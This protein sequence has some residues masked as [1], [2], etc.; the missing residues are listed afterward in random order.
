MSFNLVIKLPLT[1][2]TIPLREY[3]GTLSQ[4]RDQTGIEP[5]ASSTYPRGNQ[6]S[7]YPNLPPP[8]YAESVFGRFNVKAEN[9]KY[10][11]GDFE[12]VP[13]YAMYN[14]NCRTPKNNSNNLDDMAFP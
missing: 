12:F 6:F 7:A 3:F 4:S 9:D 13:K 8:T 2:G 14:T 11:G 1:I 5:S 10:L